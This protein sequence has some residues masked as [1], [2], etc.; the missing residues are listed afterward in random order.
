VSGFLQPYELGESLEYEIAFTKLGARYRKLRLER[1]M[2][3]EDVIGHGFSVRHYQQLEAGRPH[4]V[5][6]FFRV[7]KM[8]NVNPEILIKGIFNARRSK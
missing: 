5:K 8:F 3:Q 7:S 2:V 4:S 6:T 1:K